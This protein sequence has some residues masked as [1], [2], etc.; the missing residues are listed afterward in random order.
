LPAAT[1]EHWASVAREWLN[2]DAVLAA[3]SASPLPVPEALPKISPRATPGKCRIGVARDAAF[4]F[5]YEANLRLLR[6]CGAELVPF[7]PLEHAVLP[8][9]DGVYFGGGY[10]ELHAFA[11]ETNAMF[12]ES[13]R[14]FIEEGGPVYAECGGL[15]YLTGAIRLASGEVHRMVG[16]I[17]AEAVMSHS[18]RVIG[19]VEAEASRETV[20]GPAGTRLRGHEFRHTE[21]RN[22]APR[23]GAD[24]AFVLTSPSGKSL[25]AA[26]IAVDNVLATY[27]HA[28]F[29]SNPDVPRHFVERCASHRRAREK[30]RG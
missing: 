17:P 21:L 24:D 7:S 28:H 29:A 2:L 4:Q 20:L 14:R 30:S 9:V 18:L 6:E 15:M 13:V 19:Y 5:Y 16:A 8:E 22:L 3:A 23:F 25:G 12:R 26:G 10:P 27:V 1:L 11:L